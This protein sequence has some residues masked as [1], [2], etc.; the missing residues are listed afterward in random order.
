MLGSYIGLVE[1]QF[2]MKSALPHWFRVTWLINAPM[3]L[4]FAVRIVWE[5]TVW[6]WARG[7]QAVGFSLM[8]IHPLFAVAGVIC[9]T[10]LVLWFITATIYLAGRWKICSKTEWAMVVLSLFVTLA[11]VLPDQFFAR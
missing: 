10:L 8:H 3:G 7:P 4:L 6:T 9:S 1:V 11:I 5:K 2:Y